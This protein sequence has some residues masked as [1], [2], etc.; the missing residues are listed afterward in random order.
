MDENNFITV[1]SLLCEPSRA[2]IVWNLLD[3]RAYTASE[4]ALVSD[5]SPSSL[6][7]H[8]SKLL[9][10]NI[11]RVDVQGRHRYYSFFNSDVAY[12]VE[13]LANLGSDGLNATSNKELIKTGVKYCRTCYDHLAGYVGVMITEAMIEQGYLVKSDK[14]YLVTK[15]GWD[16]FS[17]F[18]ISEVDFKKSRRPLTRQCLDWSERRPHLAGNLGAVFLKK[19]LE[20]NWL[21]KVKFSREV[22]ITSKGKQSLNDLL[23]VVL[24]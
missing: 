16:W 13:A 4:L 5:L 2:K 24:F 11:L 20:K 7:N 19:M 17:Q 23:G 14:I 21:K 18:G 10:G 15:A 1:A 6:S 8:L 12:A 3:G 9:E 22:V